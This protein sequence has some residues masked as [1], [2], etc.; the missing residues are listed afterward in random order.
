MTMKN[1]FLQ[2]TEGVTGEKEWTL[3]KTEDNRIAWYIYVVTDWDSY[4]VLCCDIL[5][6]IHF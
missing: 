3:D 4:V 5:S 6:Y 2:M 1:L